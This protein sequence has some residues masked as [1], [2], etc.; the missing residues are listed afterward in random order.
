[1]DWKLIITSGHFFRMKNVRVDEE[2]WELGQNFWKTERLVDINFESPTLT[3]KVD[4]LYFCCLHTRDPKLACG[5]HK[6]ETKRTQ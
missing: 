2:E 1:M 6:A 5:C 4:L 3:V